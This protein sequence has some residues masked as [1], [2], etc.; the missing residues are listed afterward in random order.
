MHRRIEFLPVLG[1]LGVVREKI[2]VANAVAE[3]LE[4]A[5]Y[6]GLGRDSG[7]EKRCKEKDCKG[8]SGAHQ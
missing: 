8:V 1:E 2:V 7:G 4:R 5:R 6:V 3:F